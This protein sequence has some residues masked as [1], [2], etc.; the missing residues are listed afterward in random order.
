[1]ELHIVNELLPRIWN[2]IDAE[3]SNSGT[4]IRKA[5]GR[6]AQPGGDRNPPASDSVQSNLGALMSYR[7]WDCLWNRVS[8]NLQKHLTS[9]LEDRLGDDLRLT[10]SIRLG[11]L[12]GGVLGFQLK[13]FAARIQ[14]KGDN[15]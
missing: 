4:A 2:T 1:M 5:I 10:I 3:W 13:K 8:V 9:S 12:A 6:F 7:H 14:R 11:A 15:V